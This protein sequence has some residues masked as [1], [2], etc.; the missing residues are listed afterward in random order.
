LGGG[1]FFGR[2]KFTLANLPVS[3][4]ALPIKP[5][6]NLNPFKTEIA[7]HKCFVHH[8]PAF[9]G[10][11]QIVVQINAGFYGLAAAPAAH[12]NPIGVIGDGCSAGNY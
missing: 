6:R 11:A 1:V 3:Q 9:I 7:A 10:D 8:I 2:N 12:I 4:A 5:Q